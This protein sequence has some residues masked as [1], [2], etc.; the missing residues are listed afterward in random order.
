MHWN[1]SELLKKLNWLSMK[2][3]RILNGLSL[4]FKTLNGEG[5]DYLRDMF[6]L[7]S[8]ISER[9]TRSYPQNIWIP[10]EHLSAIH[11]KS[12]RIYI[13]RV[14][15]NLP[16]DIKQSKSLNIFKKKVKI[17]LLNCEIDIP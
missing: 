16:V 5:P 15:N 7:I 4:L 6:T 9:N 12:F 8:E 17:A 10:N 3:R 11:H 13:P 14:W 1:S 2:D